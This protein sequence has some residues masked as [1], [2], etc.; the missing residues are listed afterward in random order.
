LINNPVVL[1]HDE[2]TA[3]LDD[4]GAAEIMTLLDSLNA[5]GMTIVFSTHD[6]SIARHAVR[7]V[8]MPMTES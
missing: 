6:R 5:A 4:S 7:I 8:E 1:L 3:D 2:P